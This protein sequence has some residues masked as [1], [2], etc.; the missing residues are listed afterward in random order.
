MERE[1]SVRFLVP[2]FGEWPSWFPVFA[3]TASYNEQFQW[4]LLTDLEPPE[5]PSN[6]VVIRFSLAKLLERAAVKLGCTVRK[7]FYSICDLRPAFGVLFQEEL[8]GADFWGHTDID[9]VWGRLELFIS[10]SN[11]QRYD[12]LSSRRS[13]IAGHCTIYRN[14]ERVNRLFEDIA[15]YRQALSNP[16]LCRLN[17]SAMAQVIRKSRDV[18]VYWHAQYV[19]DQRELDRRPYDWR[20][21][22][23]FILD[24]RDVERAYVHFASWKRGVKTDFWNLCTILS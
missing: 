11:L 2:Y 18:R 12:I 6:V 22:N 8:A 14:C 23:G 17:E 5:L 7:D 21:E 10:H 4:Y 19:V 15:G 13:A 1:I 16:R 20:W 9:V 3:I 24:N